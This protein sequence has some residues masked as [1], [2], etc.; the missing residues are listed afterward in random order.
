MR[1][2]RITSH[3]GH[4]LNIRSNHFQRA[5]DSSS[6]SSTDNEA[7]LGD[8]KQDGSGILGG[9]CQNRTS[10]TSGSSGRRCSSGDG[11]DG[12]QGDGEEAA[13]YFE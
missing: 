11:E 13:P 12:E 10:N 5:S 6:S 8:S 3:H 4:V 9:K 1:F 7:N 2:S